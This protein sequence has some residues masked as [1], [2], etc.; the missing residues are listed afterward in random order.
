ML[1]VESSILSVVCFIVY[2]VQPLQVFA[3]PFNFI[4]NPLNRQSHNIEITASD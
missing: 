4:I 2:S 3:Q 1:N